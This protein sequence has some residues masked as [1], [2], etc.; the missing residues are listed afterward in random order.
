MLGLYALT[1]PA[2]A[3]AA[4]ILGVILVVLLIVRFTMQKK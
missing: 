2:W 1:V 3:W 4:I